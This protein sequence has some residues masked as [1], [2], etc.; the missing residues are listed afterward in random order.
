MPMALDGQQA[1]FPVTLT[2]VPPFSRFPQ[3]PFVLANLGRDG[4]PAWAS[5]TA[6]GGSVC[7][8]GGMG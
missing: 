8:G 3:P 2:A 1:L 7:V 5:E 6:P 4:V